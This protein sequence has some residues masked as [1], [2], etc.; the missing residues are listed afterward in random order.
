[1]SRTGPY[2]GNVD[3]IN[4]LRRKNNG[5]FFLVDSPDVRTGDG[6]SLQNSLED[7]I[8]I[9]D[10]AEAATKIQITTTNEDIDLITAQDFENIIAEEFLTN[11][12]YAIN[13]YVLYEGDLY[14][15]IVAHNAGN[16]DDSQ[17]RQV[18]INDEVTDINNQMGELKTQTNVNMDLIPLTFTEN[19]AVAISSSKI[20]LQDGV[21][22]QASSNNFDSV[23]VSCNK[24]DKFI[25][26]G[27]GGSTARLW[28][29]VDAEGNVLTISAS[30]AVEEGFDL[31]APYGAAWF[32]IN[33][34]KTVETKPCYKGQTIKEL[35]S[36]LTEEDNM[37]GGTVKGI[38]STDEFKPG[39]Y[40]PFSG[41]IGSSEVGVVPENNKTYTV[42][43]I[44]SNEDINS[45]YIDSDIK[46]IEST[47]N[48]YLY[49][50]GYNTSTNTVDGRYDVST[51]TW[52]TSQNKIPVS[53]KINLYSILSLYPNRKFKLCIVD[54]STENQITAFDALQNV[55]YYYSA[56]RETICDIKNSI[57]DVGAAVEQIVEIKHSIAINLNGYIK[58][59]LNVGAL[60][61]IN[62][63]A[64][65]DYKCAVIECAENEIFE[66]NL[67]GGTNARP[68]AFVD[69]DLYLL[70]RCASSAYEDRITAPEDAKYL[71]I[72][73]KI[74][75][76]TGSA[77][78]IT[79]SSTLVE[80]F[81]EISEDLS[82]LSNTDTDL[83]AQITKINDSLID[84]TGSFFKEYEL[85]KGK[86]APSTAGSGSSAAHIKISPD[87]VTQDLL[88][89]RTNRL[90]N[91]GWVD[92]IDYIISKDNIYMYIVGM[93][94]IT[95]DPYGWYYDGA[96][97]TS[98]TGIIATQFI[99]ISDIK[100]S[101]PNL[102]YKLCIVDISTTD[103][104]EP[105]SVLDKV[106]IF[107]TVNRDEIIEINNSI[108]DFEKGFGKLP[109]Y[110]FENDY[111][112]N[113]IAEIRDNMSLFGRNSFTFAFITDPHWGSNNKQSPVLLNYIMKNTSV[114]NVICGG[115]I[116]LQGL[117]DDMTA[118]M[119]DYI[120][121]F[122]Y[123]G[124]T[125]PVTC[126]NHDRNWNQ[127]GGQRE[128]PERKF[129]D[130]EV[131][132]LMEAQYDKY[133]MV[134]YTETGFNFYI[135]YPEANTRVIFIDTGDFELDESTGTYGIV[136]D[137]Y[138][139]FA[140]ILMDSGDK[141]II[142]IPHVVAVNSIGTI[143]CRISHAYNNRAE[144]S[145]EDLTGDFTYDFENAQ[146]HV[147]VVIGGHGHND[148]ITTPPNCGV[149][150][151]MTDTDSTITNSD[152]APTA[153][154][155]NEQA[156]DIVSVS[157]DSTGPNAGA[158]K[159]V[160]IGRGSD[161]Q[162]PVS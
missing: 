16:W 21:P 115:D 12:T 34:S 123:Y 45:G 154:T 161:R 84:L 130:N 122:R 19:T 94:K 153:G 83:Q 162:V 144:Y 57:D 92:Y 61:N 76:G 29:F 27:K 49:V 38:F 118:M 90:I 131:W 108:K 37:M 30:N 142:V 113:K 51:N 5:D 77:Y 28:L 79:G 68:W 40:N 152:I 10:D 47:G 91:N 6:I 20:T 151:I 25:V 32:V 112:T 35:N 117:K 137:D 116:I 158:V 95:N 156:F 63:T 3:L 4:G 81:S 26:T 66:L 9:N 50:I 134:Y 43:G 46:A 2:T 138:E 128:Y 33:N 65:D 53:Q 42:N 96:W 60:V 62:P 107:S 52:S 110:Y 104:I 70:E 141:N 114:N 82:D 109:D 15:F 133:E 78:K 125:F 99:S 39:R 157:Y 139:T 124:I 59:N 67:Q 85:D 71:I 55:R 88:G 22:V 13:Q 135:D 7:M 120:N 148:R 132:A 89:V 14:K 48:I 97:S 73:Q 93:D 155:I 24:G 36:E 147:Y 100:K 56:S 160:R 87:G 23:V 41:A 101:K 1:M 11:K 146:G 44:R 140:D 126:G 64:N 86:Y 145:N 8:K 98:S 129:T 72:N 136:W 150:W 149:S 69:D 74:S 121:A 143:L 103:Q 18:K 159:L 58:T 111:I 17:V 105:S 127:Y 80:Q 119:T 54:I 106:Q 102:K 75:S 31:V